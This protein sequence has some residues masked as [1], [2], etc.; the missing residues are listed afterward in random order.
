MSKG[1]PVAFHV[2]DE[3]ALLL[4]NR[5]VNPVGLRMQNGVGAGLPDYP[6]QHV[7]LPLRVRKDPIDLDFDSREAER[8]DYCVKLCLGT[9]IHIAVDVLHHVA[10]RRDHH[11]DSLAAR[12]L[13]QQAM[14]NRQPLPDDIMNL[15]AHLDEGVLRRNA[16]DAVHELAEGHPL[17][18][19]LRLE[20]PFLRLYHALVRD[21]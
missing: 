15:R 17:A 6:D 18:F 3:D 4:P 12:V 10:N 11:R 16:L 21:V 2:H 13:F 9:L 7:S 8:L 1:L 5:H 20:R 19:E 14:E